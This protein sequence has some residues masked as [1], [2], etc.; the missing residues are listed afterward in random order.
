M[1]SSKPFSKLMAAGVIALALAG[2]F[3]PLNGEFGKNN[4]TIASELALVD[5]EPMQDTLGHFLVQNVLFE[6]NGGTLPEKPRYKLTMKSTN[7]LSTPVIDSSSGRADVGSVL[8]S[9]QFVLTRL[10]TGAEIGRGVVNSS[11]TFDR[12]SQRFSAA[13]ARRDAETRVAQA[14]AEDIRTR[15]ATL[16]L[17]QK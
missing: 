11:A 16:L 9:V 7:A 15:V 14:M 8:T 17:N 12:M 3:R 10:D 5:V 6:L 13:R 1:W 4:S 2:C